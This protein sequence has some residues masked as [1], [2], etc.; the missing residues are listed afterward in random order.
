MRTFTPL[1]YYFKLRI[2]WEDEEKMKS[3][4]WGELTILT[5]LI[6]LLIKL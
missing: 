3:L 1:P 2:I 4:V 6:L 5:L